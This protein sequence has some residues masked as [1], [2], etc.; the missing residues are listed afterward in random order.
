MDTI[1]IF[2]YFCNYSGRREIWQ[3]NSCQA[4]LQ[5]S[6]PARSH[7]GGISDA[8]CSALPDKKMPRPE[9]LQMSIPSNQVVFLRYDFN[10]TGNLTI[11]YL[12]ASLLIQVSSLRFR[13]LSAL[14]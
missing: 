2:L 6:F 4:C 8:S 11:Q 1:K 7:I 3:K 12:A 10:Y 13:A 5:A 14:E 9:Q